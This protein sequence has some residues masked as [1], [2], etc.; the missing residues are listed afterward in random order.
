MSYRSL[1]FWFGKL[2]TKRI[3][4]DLLQIDLTWFDLAFK[5]SKYVYFGYWF[6]NSMIL[7]AFINESSRILA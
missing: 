1:V 5:Y 3:G 2:S 4:K 7:I 6:Q